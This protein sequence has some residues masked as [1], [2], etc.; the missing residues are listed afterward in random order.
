MYERWY[1]V[2]V[3][4]IVKIIDNEYF[5]ADLVLISSRFV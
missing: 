5:P 1:E 3:G 4:D 2:K